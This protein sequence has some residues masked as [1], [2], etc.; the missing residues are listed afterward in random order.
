VPKGF[1]TPPFRAKLLIFSKEE[2]E[3]GYRK[4]FA[5][6]EPDVNSA[7]CVQNAVPDKAARNGGWNKVA[8]LPCKNS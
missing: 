3:M 4:K 2:G 8:A 5:P 6:E 7:Q 1:N